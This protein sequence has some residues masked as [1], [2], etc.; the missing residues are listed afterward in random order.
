MFMFTYMICY[1]G[2]CNKV[3]VNS[4]KQL[5]E[6]LNRL[7]IQNIDERSFPLRAITCAA[8][9]SRRDSPIFVFT[10][11][12]VSNQELLGEVEAIVAE[13]NLQINSIIVGDSSQ[14]S[15]RLVHNRNIHKFKHSYYRRQNIMTDIYQELADFSDGQNIQI[16][17]EEISDIGPVITYSATQGSNT[18][19]QYSDNLSG[20]TNLSVMVNSYAFEILICINGENITVSVYSPQGKNVS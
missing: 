19:F 1:V 5:L 15:K 12:S 18:I 8:K 13:K 2:M 6:E 17:V 4:Y 14:I 10:D 9:A 20:L 16:P 11:G 7:N 3:Q